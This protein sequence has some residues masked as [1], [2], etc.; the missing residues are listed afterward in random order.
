MEHA[1]PAQLLN[2]R[3]AYHRAAAAWPGTDPFC[4]RLEWLLPARQ[5]FLPHSPT[6]IVHDGDSFVIMAAVS[7]TDRPCLWVPFEPM[8]GFAAPLAGPGA[9]RLLTRLQHQLARHCLCIPG[10][11][12]TDRAAAAVARSLHT[13]H[14]PHPGPLTHRCVA[15]LDGG[16]DGYLGR[17]SNRLRAAAT[18][19]AR[20]ARQAGIRFTCHTS[21]PTGDCYG[22]ILDV[23]RRSWKGAS[24][25]GVDQPPMRQLYAG[26]IELLS[27][28]TALRLI[29]AWADQAPV[30]YIYGACPGDHY[31]GLQMSF[32][33]R[34]RDLSLGNAL[35][36]RMISWLADSGCRT[37]DMGMAIAY[38]HRW[39]EQVRTTR[40][41]LLEPC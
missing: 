1:T 33:R 14:R 29:L 4:M 2:W 30:G 17:R 10:L 18:R 27:T 31:R 11:P 37:Y 23:E 28:G 34:L 26:V 19:A 9:T 6:C 15:S 5:A 16:L 41:I 38:K 12:D 21:D 32:D 35:Q 7:H 13:T 20:L 25:Q 24:N 40:S 22:H 8:W 39:A 36:L 3:D